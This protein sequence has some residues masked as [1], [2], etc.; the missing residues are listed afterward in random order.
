MDTKI[1]HLVL[2]GS[3]LGAT[4]MAAM[5]PRD[6]ADNAAAAEHLNNTLDGLTELRK[7]S[8]GN[9]DEDLAGLEASLSLLGINND[10]L[11]KDNDVS[12]ELKKANAKNVLLSKTIMELG[13]DDTLIGTLRA[14]VRLLCARAERELWGAQLLLREV[15]KAKEKFFERERLIQEDANASRAKVQ[16]ML[17]TVVPSILKKSQ[18]NIYAETKSNLGATLRAKNELRAMLILENYS[19]HTSEA[20]SEAS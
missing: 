3:L 15:Q 9:P 19:G 5:D 20:S 13:N 14:E 10:E 2:L 4:N 1:K 12:S 18:K 7:G 16:A 6:K 17:A 11:S 8:S